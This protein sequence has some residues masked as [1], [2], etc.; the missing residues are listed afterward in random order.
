MST[1]SLIAGSLIVAATF[2]GTAG[3]VGYVVGMRAGLARGRAEGQEGRITLA[4]HQRKVELVDANGKV[5]DRA[6]AIMLLDAAKAW[7]DKGQW[8]AAGALYAA[9]SDAWGEDT[10][11]YEARERLDLIKMHQPEPR[12]PTVEIVGYEWE[13]TEIDH[14]TY[15]STVLFRADADLDHVQTAITYVDAHR[16]R[17][18]TDGPVIGGMRAGETRAVEVYARLSDDAGPETIGWRISAE[19]GGRRV[20]AKVVDRQLLDYQ[21]R[22]RREK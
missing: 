22:R 21:E 13:N 8:T 14:D 5:T 1:R 3:A 2:G 6:H 16:R 11:G 9:I 7:G 20:Q 4:E 19:I 15:K 10:P 17:V 12:P 18:T